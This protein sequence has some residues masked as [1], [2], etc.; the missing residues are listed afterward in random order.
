MAQLMKCRGVERL[1]RPEGLPPG[2]ADLVRSRPVASPVSAVPYGGRIRHSC[3]DRLTTPDGVVFRRSFDRWMLC[4]EFVG[5]WSG[6]LV[7]VDDAIGTAD[8]YR[9]AAGGNL[10]LVGF[11]FQRFVG[12]I[13]LRKPRLVEVDPADFFALVMCP[14]KSLTCLG[15]NH[16]GDSK[17]AALKRKTLRPR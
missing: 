16:H 11:D 9:A 1:G 12:G 10:Y 5:S 8:E 3:N 17:P 6:N 7:Q 14:P 4:A 2:H 13:P 15:V